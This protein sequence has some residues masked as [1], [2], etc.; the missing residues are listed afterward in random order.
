M[1]HWK[2]SQKIHTKFHQKLSR[3]QWGQKFPKN[4]RPS[5]IPV[6]GSFISAI[7]EACR[8]MI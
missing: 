1:E 8:K 3:I 6:K 7:I 4:N 5:P 2:G